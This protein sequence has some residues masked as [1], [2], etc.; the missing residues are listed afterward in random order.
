VLVE[1]EV[2]VVVEPPLLSKS[3]EPGLPQAPER[4]RARARVPSSSH[5]RAVIVNSESKVRGRVG[6]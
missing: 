6:R 2:L 5:V 1:V 3:F 4:A